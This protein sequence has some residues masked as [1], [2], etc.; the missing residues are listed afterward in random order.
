[1]KM[2]S[3][4]NQARH[5]SAALTAELPLAL[6]ILFFL[7]TFPMIDMATML[8]RYSFMVAATRDGAHAAGQ[9]RTFW[10]DSAPGQLSAKNAAASAV[11]ATAAAFTEVSVSSVQAQIVSTSLTSSQVTRYSQPLGQPADTTNNLYEVEIVVKGQISPIIPMSSTTWFPVVPGLTAAIP[12]S[13]AA[14]EYCENPQ[15]LNI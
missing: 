7:F 8:L 6:W 2:K 10:T 13:V 3:P 5:A 15:G 11:A 14:R 12:V 1:M 4:K 9:A